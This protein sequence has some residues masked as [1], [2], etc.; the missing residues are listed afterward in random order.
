ME[1]DVL[2]VRWICFPS[3]AYHTQCPLE[4]QRQLPQ[5]LPHHCPCQEAQLAIS[6]YSKEKYGSCCH[7]LWAA[8]WYHTGVAKTSG[9]ACLLLTD[10]ISNELWGRMG[11]TL[12]VNLHL[13][14]CLN[15]DYNASE[16]DVGSSEEWGMCVK[17][18][19]IA[20]WKLHLENLK[21]LKK[22]GIFYCCF[23]G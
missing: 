23:S 16:A 7:S 13:C 22:R 5:P 19:H 15:I 11:R 21:S 4:L 3:Q 9:L 17:T 14:S 8:V 12:R 18:C 10:N 1:K 20:T 2:H 6:K